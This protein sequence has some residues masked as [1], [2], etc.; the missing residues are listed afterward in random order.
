MD[1]CYDPMRS[2]RELHPKPR[3]PGE[4]EPRPACKE[5]DERHINLRTKPWDVAAWNPPPAGDASKGKALS[6]HGFTLIELLMVF[7]ISVVLASV[8]FSYYNRYVQK[9]QLL[10]VVNDIRFL[11]REIKT[12][13]MVYEK[14]PPSLATIGEQ[15][16]LDR[17]GRPFQ[18]MR[19]Q[20][21]YDFMGPELGKGEQR[22][23]RYMNPVN[24]DFDLYSLG[25]DGETSAQFTS[26]KGKDDIVRANNG[27]YCGLA[28]D[29]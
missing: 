1:E 6:S 25:P 29:H 24:T 20:D 23:D 5:G 14:L 7:A 22:K 2:V 16:Y 3:G 28:A 12:Y 11:E 27:D 26:D 19:I 13:E 10:A 8:S 21:A 4:D 15:N 17:W 18:Y 9:A